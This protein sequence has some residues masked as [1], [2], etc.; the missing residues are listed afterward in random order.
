MS[1]DFSKAPEGATH[2]IVDGNS[3]HYV[4]FGLDRWWIYKGEDFR[5]LSKQNVWRDLSGHSHPEPIPIPPPSF[6]QY[7]PETDKERMLCDAVVMKCR[8]IDVERLSVNFEW[9]KSENNA[10]F[11]DEEYRRAPKLPEIP[12]E[13]IDDKVA[14]IEIKEDALIYRASD[15]F[16]VSYDVHPLKL[17]LTDI[18][19]PVTVKRPG[20]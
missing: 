7:T 15:G 18:E 10:V 3:I 9:V 8:G 14:E 5:G 1:I 2:Y 20:V 12:W 6:G 17:D 16:E 11:T 19:L 4:K 13:W